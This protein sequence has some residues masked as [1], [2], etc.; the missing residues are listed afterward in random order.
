MKAESISFVFSFR[1][2][3][4]ILSLLVF[5]PWA[6][7]VLLTFLRGASALTARVLT[8]I[9]SLST[10]AFA[11][12]LLDAFDPIVTA[13]QFVERQSWIAA[14]NVHYHLGLDGLSLV[15]VLLTGIITPVALLASW[16]L[17]R[18]A[19]LFGALFL[20][21]QGAALGVFLALDFFHWFV[22]WE[23]SL[24]PAFFLIKLWGGRDATR[25]AYQFVI[26]TIGGS[27]FMLL[28][29]AALFATVGTLDFAQLAQLGADGS[30]AAKLGAGPLQFI[31][32]GVLL[33]LA[34]KVPLWPFHTW[35][36]PAYA[37][38]PT[39]AS[40]FLTGVM[41]K[42]GVYGFLRILWPIFPQQLHDATPWLLALALGGVVLGAWAALRQ[43]DLKRMVAY[44]SLNHLSYCLLAVFAIS[45]ATGR[46][47]TSSEAA[48][49]ALSGTILQMFNHGLSAA[50]L[51]ACVG[52][53]ETRSGGKRG[54]TD[55]GGVRSAAPIFAGICG[56]AMFSSLGLPGL[57]GFVGEFLI[58]RG[59]FGLDP[60]AAA[61]A[62]LG[63]L[64][65]A[66]FLLTFWQRVFHGQ[67]AGAAAGEFP[68]LRGVEYAALVPLVALMIMLGVAP[69]LLTR[70]INPLVTAWAGHLVLP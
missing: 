34:V 17:E 38:A 22:F 57:N 56:I 47:G 21:L 18:S 61:V 43:T 19:R 66:L 40:M 46:S 6:G 32:L 33:G 63:L 1:F 54:L 16:R 26:Y 12:F 51:F 36:P 50:A 62:C 48:T 23:L 28:G 7:A 15:L 58:F 14:L 68:D 25:A 65:T 11:V 8:L 52:I 5:T 13:P 2:P 31:F 70:L 39:G 24:V 59:V 35:L 53:L 64:G 30:L 55:F 45:Y 29:F 3:F 60:G 67:H 20:T 41:S 37:E 4:P 44:S 27:A 42:M 9:F 49:A 69:Q 10:L